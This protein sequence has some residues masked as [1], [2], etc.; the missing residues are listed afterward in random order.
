[1]KRNLLLRAITSLI[2][3]SCGED[4]NEDNTEQNTI[5]QKIIG[6]WIIVKKESNGTN[7]LF[8]HLA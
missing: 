5:S 7:V 4:R 8:W 3:L 1:M 6:T 2:L